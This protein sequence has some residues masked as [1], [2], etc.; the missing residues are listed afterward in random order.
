MS[1]E[2]TVV[3]A[4]VGL[5]IGM[6]KGGF[7]PVLGA[8]ATPILSQVMPVSQAV[9]TALPLLMIGDVFALRLYWNQWNFRQLQLLIPSAV[10]GVFLGAYLLTT[11]PDTLLRPTLGLFSLLIVAYKLVSDRLSVQSYRPHNWHGYVAGGASGFGS[12]VAN[13]GGP[14]F[15]AYMLLQKLDPA[16]FMGTTTLFFITVN[17]IK[18]PSFWLAGLMD[19]TP[20]LTI[21]VM[22]PVVFV[23]S[24]VG[25]HFVKSVNPKMFETVMMVLL[26]LASTLLFI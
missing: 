14:P 20:I 13:A 7:G 12:A 16:I 5:L 8:L 15:T 24:A 25:R 2:V 4:G 21:L 10:L 1:I 23:G 9:A 11:L 19:D 18:L 17:L 3:I 26:I 22:L 6:A